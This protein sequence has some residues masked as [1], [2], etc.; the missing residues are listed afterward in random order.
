MDGGAQF[1]VNFEIY[2]KVVYTIDIAGGKQLEHCVG[3]GTVGS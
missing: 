2:D 1:C 3:A